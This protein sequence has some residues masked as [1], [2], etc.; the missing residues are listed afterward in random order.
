MTE[1]TNYSV[2]GPN[3]E[4]MFRRCGTRRPISP[5][6]ETF[7][8]R[9]IPCLDHGY[10]ELLDYMGTDRDVVLAA[11]TTTASED[12][13]SPSEDRGLLRYMLRHQHMTPFE[14]ARARFRI[15]L[16]I[17]VARQ[18]VR[19]RTAG[20]NEYSTRYSE[21]IDVFYV[22]AL[23]H[24][25]AQA[26][27]NRQGRGEV[28]APDVAE[29]VRA[30]M[31]AH[32]EAAQ[33]LYRQ[34]ADDLGVAR[35]LARD[36]M[37]LSLY[38]RWVWTIDL[39]NL[40]HLLGLR[41]DGH[42]QLEIRTFAGALARVAEAWVPETWAAF[43]DYRLLAVTLSRAEGC[44]VGELVNHVLNAHG[45][46]ADDGAGR[47]AW[48]RDHAAARSKLTGRELDEAVDKMVRLLAAAE[49]EVTP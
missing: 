46:G 47:V 1:E 45:L 48:L 8:G 7:V 13:K 25:A 12:S 22:P 17:S 5:G 9:Q 44:V 40:L 21:P 15:Q 38:T 19:H 32:G 29:R 18:L 27:T 10:V 34:L 4:D 11:R 30:L 41:L 39:R 37:P 23:H 24:V 28:L 2:P 35:E 20:L 36:V 16:P 33:A 49:S 42:A 43:R 26:R 31:T 14:M 3:Y 6:A